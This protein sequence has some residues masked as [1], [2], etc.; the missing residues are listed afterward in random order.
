MRGGISRYWLAPHNLLPGR[1]STW[2]GMKPGTSTAVAEP[3]EPWRSHGRHW[4]RPRCPA[5]SRCPA[6]HSTAEHPKLYPL[7][8][9]PT[10]LETQALLP[11]GF[12]GVAAVSRPLSMPPPLPFPLLET[13]ASA[14]CKPPPHT[15]TR[16]TQTV[17]C[18]LSQRT[19]MKTFLILTPVLARVT[20]TQ[21]RY[22]RHGWVGVSTRRKSLSLYVTG[23]LGVHLGMY[24]C[25]SQISPATSLFFLRL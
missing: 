24:R 21:E 2:P 4:P 3:G 19:M 16:T 10:A 1:A 23:S 8:A 9:G 13:S 5:G 17:P 7:G 11:C 20:V 25:L 22:W 6:Q 12:S 15:H 14:L 18:G